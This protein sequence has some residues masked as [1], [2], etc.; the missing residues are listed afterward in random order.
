MNGQRIA[1]V[2]SQFE[3]TL[4]S[5]KWEKPTVSKALTVATNCGFTCETDK[6]CIG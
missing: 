5:S 2:N 3:L 1:K 6:P 4:G